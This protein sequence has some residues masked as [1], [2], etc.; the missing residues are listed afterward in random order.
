VKKEDYAHRVRRLRLELGLTQHTLAERLHVRPQV[1]ASWEQGRREP[2]A[3]SYQQLARVA[4]PQEAW[5]FLEK[6]GITKE[7]IRAKWRAQGRRD[8]RGQ[9]TL[10]DTIPISPNRQRADAPPLPSKGEVRAMVQIPILCD[11]AA[12]K[13]PHELAPGDIESYIALPLRAAPRGHHAYTGIYMRGEAMQPAL[14]DGYIAVID[15]LNRNASRLGGR[16]VVARLDSVI[17]VRRLAATEPSG[18]LV[19]R[20]DNPEYSEIS[21]APSRSNPIVGD[22]VFWWGTQR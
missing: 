14:R 17:V 6:L 4:P 13:H 20:A 3:E 7:L 11:E 5:F 8:R 9:T 21:I 22:V 15:H 18:R 16:I 19:L 2:S 10:Q 1:V 12:G